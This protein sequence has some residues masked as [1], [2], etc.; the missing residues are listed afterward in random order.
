MI[1]LEVGLVSIRRGC[2]LQLLDP[3]VENGDIQALKGSSFLSKGDGTVEEFKVKRSHFNVA[4][5]VLV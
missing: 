1:D 2:V 5:A 4:S 3:R